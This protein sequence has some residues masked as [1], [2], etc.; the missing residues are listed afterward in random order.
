MLYLFRESKSWELDHLLSMLEEINLKGDREEELLSEMRQIVGKELYEYKSQDGSENKFLEEI[1]EL[2]KDNEKV[3]SVSD[4]FLH[5]VLLVAKNS[6]NERRKVTCTNFWNTFIG[7]K[8]DQVD[9][10]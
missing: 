2:L 4:G 5:I 1:D 9:S 10:T 8:K 6:R 3:I 7:K